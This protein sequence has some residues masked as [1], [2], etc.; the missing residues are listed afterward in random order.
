MQD[1]ANQVRFHCHRCGVPMNGYGTLAQGNG[2][3]LIS[4]THNDIYEVKKRDREVEIVTTERQMDMGRIE[5]VT[6]YM[7]N[8]KR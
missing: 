5:R 7:K 1:F 3:E 2:K 6:D 4:I 8:A